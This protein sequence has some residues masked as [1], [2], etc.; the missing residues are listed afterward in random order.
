M[1][2]E[3]HKP[4]C[5]CGC[6]PNVMSLHEQAKERGRRRAEKAAAAAAAAAATA[7]TAATAAIAAAT[8]AASE[9]IECAEATLPMV[10]KNS[11]ATSSGIDGMQA[12]GDGSSAT[13]EA[14]DRALLEVTAPGTALIDVRDPDSYASGHLKGASNFP[15]ADIRSRTA[16]M[17]PQTAGGIHLVS[18]PGAILAEA[19]AFLRGE[20][21]DRP[22]KPETCQG[23]PARNGKGW[24]V[25]SVLETSG[26]LWSDARRLG[27]LE[28][29]STSRRL[30]A[31]SLHLPL[32]V[33]LLENLHASGGV[34]GRDPVERTE[35]STA[36][37]GAAAWNAIDLGCGRGRDCVW[38]AQRGWSVVGVDNQ[39]AFLTSLASFAERVAPGRVRCELRDLKK[40]AFDSSLLQ[41]PPLLVNVSR[42]MSRALLD[43]VVDSIPT[44]CVRRIP[45]SL[46]PHGSHPTASARLDEERQHAHRS[47]CPELVFT[48][49]GPGRAP[50]HTRG[51]VP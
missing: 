2:P 5:D 40:V 51:G 37:S 48:S 3:G 36:A 42:F 38:L 29:G 20:Q 43:A 21:Q 10:E 23:S 4:L 7:A 45:P 9:V 32:L 16:E 22:S 46:I 12:G 1:L 49:A 18:E 34:G 24:P 6:V 14:K 28:T 25:L 30:W 31:P 8:T 13:D 41:P 11:Q 17:P 15:L 47:Q 26:Q 35:A 27:L 39:T 44:G 19:L 50:L 33:P